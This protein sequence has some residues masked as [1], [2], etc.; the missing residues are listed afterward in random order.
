M[1]RIFSVSDLLLVTCREYSPSLFLVLLLIGS[2]WIASWEGGRQITLSSPP[3]QTH[4][5]YNLI[6]SP[7][8]A[9]TSDALCFTPLYSYPS[10]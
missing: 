4:S 2:L 1:P 10:L 7:R 6:K 5:K 9:L 3:Y 8:V